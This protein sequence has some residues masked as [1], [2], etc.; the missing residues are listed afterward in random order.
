LA[1]VA[2]RILNEKIR[3]RENGERRTI[4]K[5]EAMLKQLANGEVLR[6]PVEIGNGER[7]G[8]WRPMVSGEPLSDEEW[9]RRYG[10][11]DRAEADANA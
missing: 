5:L 10:R 1:R 6:L 7:P 8:G 4:S 3:V 9:E 11:C 2:H